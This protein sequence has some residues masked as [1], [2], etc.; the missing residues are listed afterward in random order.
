MRRKRAWRRG[1]RKNLYNVQRFHLCRRSFLLN[2]SA[3]TNPFT[4]SVAILAPGEDVAAQLNPIIPGPLVD[5]VSK[6]ITLGGIR[7]WMEWAINTDDIPADFANTITMASVLFWIAKVP[8]DPET[9]SLAYVPTPM[10]PSH[11]GD[12]GQRENLLWTK[13]YHIPLGF[14]DGTT[15]TQLIS[16]QGA[17]AT[18]YGGGTTDITMFAGPTQQGS[19]P[20][21]VKTKRTLSEYDALVFGVTSVTGIGGDA[22]SCPIAVDMYGQVAVKRSMR[23]TGL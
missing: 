11:Q 16:S 10:T 13:F 3:C 18:R 20:Y 23:K 2:G 6:G 22:S 8:C 14:N 5:N 15:T 9:N 1:R 4:D 21:Y 7:F 12:R 17:T 19:Y